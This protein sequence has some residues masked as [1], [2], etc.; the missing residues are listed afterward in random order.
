MD[1]EIQIT[2][3]LDHPC[4]SGHFPGNPIVPGVLLLDLI[5]ERLERGA[6]RVLG[7]VKFHRALLPGEDFVLRFRSAGAQLT[8]RCERPPSREGALIAEGSLSFGT[9]E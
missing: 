6:P 2:A 1:H 5:V 4:Y 7:S 9:R 8:F 3:P